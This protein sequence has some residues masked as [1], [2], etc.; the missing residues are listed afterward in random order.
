MKLPIMDRF[1]G[2]NCFK[3]IVLM[4]TNVVYCT[5]GGIWESGLRLWLF[6]NPYVTSVQTID[7]REGLSVRSALLRF[8]DTDLLILHSD[9]CKLFGEL[10]QRIL[11]IRPQLKTLVLTVNSEPTENLPVDKILPSAVSE[12]L[13]T[14]EVNTLLGV[15]SLPDANSKIAITDHEVDLLRLLCLE[16]SS[17]E[18]AEALSRSKRTI[19]GTRTR[20]MKKLEVKTSIGLVKYAIE[21]GIYSIS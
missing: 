20:L 2:L 9:L 14:K 6:K 21:K 19:E 10:W 1:I 18:I 3:T 8:R 5:T 17:E 7:V 11:E 12:S 13:F 16:K 15:E 4:K